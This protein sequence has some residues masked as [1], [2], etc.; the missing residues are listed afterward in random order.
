[1]IDLVLPGTGSQVAGG[2]F[3]RL[4]LDVVSLHRDRFG[5]PYLLEKAREAEAALFV[6]DRTLALHDH[7]VDIDLFMV[8]L[9]GVAG[10]IDEQ[11]LE[12]QSYLR[13]CQPQAAGFIHAVPHLADLE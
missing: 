10:D 11:Q 6:V 4:A 7:G 9:L 1:M 12:W 3:H 2:D 5:P 8:A 13:G